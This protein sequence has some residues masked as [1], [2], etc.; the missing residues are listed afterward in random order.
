MASLSEL[1]PWCCSSLLCA[2]A[3]D[4][5]RLDVFLAWLR[6]CPETRIVVVCHWGFI[7]YLMEHVGYAERALLKLDNCTQLRTVWHPEAPPS[8]IPPVPGQ[9]DHGR[10]YAV[11]LEPDRSAPPPLLAEYDRFCA[12]ARAA[13]ALRDCTFIARRGG[14]LHV[15]LSSFL[16]LPFELVQRLGLALRTEALRLAGRGAGVPPSESMLAW[17]VG[18]ADALSCVVN[19]ERSLYAA[20]Q[21]DSPSLQKLCVALKEMPGLQQHAAAFRTSGTYAVTLADSPQGRAVHLGDF[22]HILVPSKF[23]LLCAALGLNNGADGG[24]GGSSNCREWREQ[25]AS[26]R[27]YLCLM[28]KQEGDAGATVRREPGMVVPLFHTP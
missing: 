12:A 19:E 6:W 27:W 10:S 4:L 14:R 1:V 21:F 28:E 5:G 20:I 3:G 24:G 15:A 23:P 9:P 11:W 17:G 8:Q 22:K 18:G 13:A 16:P 25:L 7:M 2:T 26:M